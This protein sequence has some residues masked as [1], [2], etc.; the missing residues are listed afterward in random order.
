MTVN[1]DKNTVPSDLTDSFA[2]PKIKDNSGEI[3]ATGTYDNTN[4]QITYTFT[5]YVDNMKILK[6]TLN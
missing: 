1:I 4:K 2:I 5:D 3:I 6:R